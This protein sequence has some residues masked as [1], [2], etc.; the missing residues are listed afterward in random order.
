MFH[1]HDTQRQ[2]V[3]LYNSSEEQVVR[4]YWSTSSY[5][6]TKWVVFFFALNCKARLKP[7]SRKQHLVSG[8]HA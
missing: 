3:V 7:M 6:L 5:M 1:C 4:P 8:L 2:L